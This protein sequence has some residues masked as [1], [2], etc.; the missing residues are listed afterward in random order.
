MD[1]REKVILYNPDQSLNEDNWSQ[2]LNSISEF[3][4]DEEMEKRFGDDH[5]HSDQNST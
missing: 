2:K 5:H 1:A 3:D 4:I